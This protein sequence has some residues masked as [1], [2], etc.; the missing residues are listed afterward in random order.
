VRKRDKKEALVEQVQ[1]MHA[2][3]SAFLASKQRV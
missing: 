2:E 3:I 1:R